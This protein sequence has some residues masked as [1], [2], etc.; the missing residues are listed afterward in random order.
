MKTK[1]LL[2]QCLAT[3]GELG[4][5]GICASFMLLENVWNVLTGAPPLVTLS[6]L[7]ASSGVATIFM[8]SAMCRQALRMFSKQ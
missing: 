3:F 1:V 2:A 5:C 8:F 7:S 4:W 6:Y